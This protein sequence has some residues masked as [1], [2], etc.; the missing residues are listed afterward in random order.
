ML[1]REKWDEEYEDEE[2]EDEDEDEE[3]NEED[4]GDGDN[5]DHHQQEPQ[6]QLQPEHRLPK[7]LQQPF[8]PQNNYT[9]AEV[10]CLALHGNVV[11]VMKITAKRAGISPPAPTEEAGSRFWGFQQAAAGSQT[12]WAKVGKLDMIKV[13]KC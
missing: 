5:D 3:E 4:D 2:Y 10:S 9:L 6:E 8:S 13:N 7:S 12:C 11:F 1:G